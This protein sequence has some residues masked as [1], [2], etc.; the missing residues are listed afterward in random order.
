MSR[1]V[2][3][4][5]LFLMVALGGIFFYRACGRF[6]G[7]KSLPKFP[8]ARQA[9]P[10]FQSVTQAP[11]GLVNARFFE[12]RRSQ[13]KWE[14]F[15]KFAELHRT[16]NY[17]YIQT[18]TGLFYAQNS[19]NVV[20]TTSEYGRCYLDENRI[21]LEG[22]VEVTSVAGYRFTMPRLVYAG[23]QH[24]FRSHDIVSMV[25]PLVAEPTMYLRGRGLVGKIDEHQFHLA[26]Q[27][28][29]RRLLQSSQWVAVRADS[30]DFDTQNQR[31]NFE[32]NVHTVIPA[33]RV[34]S[35]R[36]EIK[37]LPT[38]ESLVAEGKVEWTGSKRSGSSDVLRFGSVS[39]EIMLEGHARVTD[40]DQNVLAG[41]RIIL[42]TADDRIIVEQAK[43]KIVN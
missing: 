35:K 21:E 36:L 29:F 10:S 4:A 25:G 33:M 34:E 31:A 17:A 1:R 8:Q 7:R 38:G 16:E 26:R 40:A 11:F 43:G 24:E 2:L 20:T 42:S 30:G 14:I 28:T 39:N 9:Q 5:C 3:A 37:T 27:V 23:K 13:R 18:V 15:A 41:Q 6:T 19:E 12:S 32:G 22:N